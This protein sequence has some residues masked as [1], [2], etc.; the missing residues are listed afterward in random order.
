VKFQYRVSHGRHYALAFQ[1]KNVPHAQ[2]QTEWDLFWIS[3]H[4]EHPDLEHSENKK[5]YAFNKNHKEPFQRI[6]DGIK[7][8]LV[9]MSL[10]FWQKLRK[11]FIVMAKK[12]HELGKPDDVQSVHGK[13]KKNQMSGVLG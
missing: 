1:E 2:T 6:E 4:H 3:N 7:I 12:P 11:N 10:K 8:L 9:K 5:A 13:L